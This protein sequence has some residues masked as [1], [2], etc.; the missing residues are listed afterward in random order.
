M[1]LSKQWAATCDAAGCTASCIFP[2]SWKRDDAGMALN[3]QGWQAGPS[4]PV[5]YCPDHSLSDED[6]TALQSKP[7]F[8][9]IDRA[10]QQ[11]AEAF[12][13]RDR[14]RSR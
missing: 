13:E 6:W 4:I 14:R 10:A 9:A 12:A 8:A 11:L 3:D 7:D 5:T 2:A 1:S